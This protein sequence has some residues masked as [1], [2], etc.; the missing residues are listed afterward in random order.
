MIQSIWPLCT[1]TVFG[2]YATG[3]FLPTSD[4]DM[5]VLNSGV[6]NVPNALRALSVQLSKKRVAKQIQVREAVRHCLSR[7]PAFQQVGLTEVK[8]GYRVKMKPLIRSYWTVPS[9]AQ[10]MTPPTHAALQ[11]S[12]SPAVRYFVSGHSPCE[13]ICEFWTGGATS[14]HQS[15]PISRSPR[16]LSSFCWQLSSPYSARLPPRRPLSLHQTGSKVAPLLSTR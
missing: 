7:A 3:L 12:P 8:L 6:D 14:P 16:R 1:P 2:S 11:S 15:C 5:V 10:F 4:M 9:S 13:T